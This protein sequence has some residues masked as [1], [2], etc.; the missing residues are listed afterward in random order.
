MCERSTSTTSLASNTIVR[1]PV[2]NVDFS[3]DKLFTFSSKTI[4]STDATSS[5]ERSPSFVV[6]STALVNFSSGK[7]IINGTDIL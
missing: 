7:L 3:A 1:R 6:S 4:L 2:N 5:A